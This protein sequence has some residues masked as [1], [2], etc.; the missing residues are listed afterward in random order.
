LYS[1]EANCETP[2]PISSGPVPSSCTGAGT[3]PCAR[4][5]GPDRVSRLNVSPGFT[6]APFTLAAS[7][8]TF[9]AAAPDRPS[10]VNSPMTSLMPSAPAASVVTLGRVRS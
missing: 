4:V 1:V 9:V 10:L 5:R 2:P 7:A 3:K 8:C 6:I